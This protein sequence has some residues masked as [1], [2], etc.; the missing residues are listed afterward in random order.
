VSNRAIRLLIPA[1]I[2]LLLPGPASSKELLRPRS[3][4]VIPTEAP[5][6]RQG[7]PEFKSDVSKKNILGLERPAPFA[8]PTAKRGVPLSLA[9]ALED[10]VNVLVLKI[11]FQP[12]VPDD[13]NTTGNGTFDLRSYDQFVAEEGHFIDPAPHSTA[14]FNSHMEA[15]RRYWYFVSD[16]KL[17]LTWDI[18]PQAESTAFRL[19]VQM[20]YYGSR[21]PWADSSIADRLGHFLIDAIT[22]ADSSAPEI[23]FS[24]YRA[25][26]IFHA[27]SDQQNNIDFINNTPDDFYTGFI[28]LGEPVSVDNGAYAVSEALQVPE[29]V[30]QDNRINALNAVLAHEFG[31][32]L[33]LVDLYNTAN[34]L[35][36]VGDFSLMDN[37]GMSV[38][39]EFDGISSSVG[40]TIPVYPDAW[41]RAYLGFDIPNVVSRGAGEPVSAAAL[42]YS[43]NEIVKV[44]VT[45]FEYFLI[46]NRQVINQGKAL[47]ADR[48][49]NVILGPGY[50]DN[51]GLLVANGE[52]DL[53]AP[54]TGMLIWHV[55]EYPA[56]L[57]YL[58][59]PGSNNFYDNTLQWDKDRRFLSIVEADGI[60]DFGGDYY[61]GFGNQNDFFGVDGRI[62]FAPYTRPSS[63][64][65]LGADSHI[66]I[67]NISSSDTIMTA[68]VDNDWLTAGWP[69]MSRPAAA[70]DPIIADIDGDGTNDVVMAAG[71]QILAWRYDGTK[72]ISNSESIGILKYDSS[73]AVYPLAVIADC[74]TNIVGHPIALDFYGNGIASLIAALTS[75]GRLY[76]VSGTD[77]NGNGR[78]DDAP[79]FPS[80]L[81]SA[82]T[83]PP[84]TVNFHRLTGQEILA[85]SGPEIHLIY[86]G[87]T[88]TPCVDSVIFT[89]HGNIISAS[90][91][92]AD[93]KNVIDFIESGNQTQVVRLSADLGSIDFSQD[94]EFSDSHQTLKYLV[95]GDIDRS[96]GLPEIVVF[97]ELGLSL[98]EPDGSV[99]WNVYNPNMLGHP[100][101]G[102]I[103]SDG[104]PEIV[105][106]GNSK[107][108]AYSYS[109]ALLSNFPID[110][111][112]H[113]MGGQIE[114][115]P[116]LGDVDGDGNPDI[117][118]GLPGGSIYAFNYHGDRVPGF[119][120][121]SSFGITHACALGDI[122]SD[123]R[124][125]LLTVENSGFVK[126][127]GIDKPFVSTNVPW[128]MAGGEPGNG[129]YL[130]SSFE[131]PI[132]I[133]DTQLPENSVF[134]Y[135]NPAR[136]STTIRYYI[137][138]ESQV[139]IDIFDF[140]GDN[141]LSVKAPGQAHVAN[142][143]VW[144]CSRV[145]SG[146]YFC[147]V[148]ARSAASKVWRMIKI[149]IVK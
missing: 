123:N 44:P 13:P 2:L 24:R 32:Q 132:T 70:S 26:V 125:D 97:N 85:F 31:H 113:D 98:I 61:T 17:N 141:V 6:R 25:I 101:L 67:T 139:S 37:N 122:N 3:W 16:K 76:L 80:Q 95:S 58:D 140:M 74:D 104:Y 59:I 43:D 23:D 93:R 79:G 148:E 46:E 92:S 83:L 34:F 38:G 73:V 35:T 107:I 129:S 63:H 15:L 19:P 9:S 111:N 131:K 68:D 134:N 64:T 115:P 62:A 90:A 11:E 48:Q 72:I 41:S 75:T 1:V 65:N 128:S 127:W 39:V 4:K 99:K 110:M 94:F 71:N 22:F 138:D 116:I 47:I 18:F 51:D 12:E 8:L 106:A 82:V 78:A 55:D 53:L 57:D 30:S 50:I 130:Q 114:S 66:S 54:G 88:D 117:I 20:N 147:R 135:P 69:Q 133:A 149:A 103:N 42:N 49:T 45:D 118:I 109:G 14:Y 100:A 56:Y 142:E 21:G 52:Y 36:Q 145:A 7:Q 29:T 143:Y 87:G 112:L 81:S 136:N 146:V 27:G 89:A 84:I 77:T 60:V 86:S 91:Y 102:D 137:N 105:V 124:I 120:L 144:D 5:P 28:R 119:P 126:A 33:G 10:T 108:Y 96:G 40:G 121:P